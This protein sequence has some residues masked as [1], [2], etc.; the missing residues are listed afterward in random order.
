MNEVE[1]VAEHTRGCICQ[2]KPCVRF[3]CD[4][5]HLLIDGKRKCQ[6]SINKYFNPLIN[7]TLN[8]GTELEINALKDFVVQQH[9]AIPCEDHFHLDADSDSN[10][11]WTLFEV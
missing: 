8:N 6:Q 7:V 2:L 10:Y 4:P 1:M 3:C 5:Q 9:F 11:K